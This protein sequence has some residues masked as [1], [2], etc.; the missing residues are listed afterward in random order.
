MTESQEARTCGLKPFASLSA[1]PSAASSTSTLSARYIG[2]GAELPAGV[3]LLLHSLF[4]SN[5]AQRTVFVFQVYILFALKAFGSGTPPH[6]S[7]RYKTP[8]HTDAAC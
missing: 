1:A 8:R 5:D 4:T 7:T 6:D 3:V 2:L